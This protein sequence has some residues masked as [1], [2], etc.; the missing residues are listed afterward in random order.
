M[1][2]WALPNAVMRR[3]AS[4]GMA[5]YAVRPSVDSIGLG[6]ETHAISGPP[7]GASAGTAPPALS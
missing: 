7:D 4:V 2:G 3:L 1:A 6:R 5:P